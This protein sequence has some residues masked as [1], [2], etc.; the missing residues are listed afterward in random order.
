MFLINFLT[1]HRKFAGRFLLPVYRVC[2]KIMVIDCFWSPCTLF[3]QHH[4]KK[5]LETVN[6]SASTSLNSQK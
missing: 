1:Q 3:A 2:M 6:L 4:W 5:E